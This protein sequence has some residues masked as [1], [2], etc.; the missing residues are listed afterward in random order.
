M[1][2]LGEGPGPLI[3]RKKEELTEGAKAIRAGKYSPPPPPPP[4]NTHTLTWLK[5]WIC[6]WWQ[7]SINH[8]IDVQTINFIV[9]MILTK[10][11]AG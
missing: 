3:L 4:T 5:V 11:V 2:D 1:A 7:L 6:Y 8:N 9:K 10:V